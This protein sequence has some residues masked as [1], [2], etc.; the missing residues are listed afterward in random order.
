MA[1]NYEPL[2]GFESPTIAGSH[3]SQQAYYYAEY[4]LAKF[5]A[6]RSWTSSCNRVCDQ[7]ILPYQSRQQRLVRLYFMVYG[8]AVSLRSTAMY[9]ESYRSTPAA[10]RRPR[11]YPARGPMG[12]LNACKRILCEAYRRHSRPGCRCWRKLGVDR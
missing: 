10:I 5:R 1:Y 6:L 4:V 8:L 2:F 9:H 11:R 12:V 3:T 7:F